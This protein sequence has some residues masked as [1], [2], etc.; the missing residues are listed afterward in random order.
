MNQTVGSLGPAACPLYVW[1]GY[2]YL[3]I[4]FKLPDETE[5][6]A[7]RSLGPAACLHLF[8][9]RSFIDLA[10]LRICERLMI[11]LRRQTEGLSDKMGWIHFDGSSCKNSPNQTHPEGHEAFGLALA[12]DDGDA[13]AASA[14]VPNP[15]FSYSLRVHRAAEEGVCGRGRHRQPRPL[16]PG[17]RTLHASDQHSQKALPWSATTLPDTVP[18]APHAARGSGVHSVGCTGWRCAHPRAGL[19]RRAGTTCRPGTPRSAAR[20]NRWKWKG[21]GAGSPAPS[22]GS[23]AR[24]PGRLV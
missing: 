8:A 23:P 13:Q 7:V 9:E 5:L 18:P 4:V 12:S 22:H 15:G 3:A 19:W 2:L 10:Q 1:R 11:L 24:V 16:A 17:L 14:P 20:W 21:R 6:R